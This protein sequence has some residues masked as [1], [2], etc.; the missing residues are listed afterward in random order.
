MVPLI[1]ARTSPG[2]ILNA[3]TITRSASVNTIPP[4]S[5]LLVK[6]KSCLMVL[7]VIYF[8]YLDFWKGY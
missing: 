7:Q 1:A 4:S 2:S 6:H 5:K 3:S 8:S